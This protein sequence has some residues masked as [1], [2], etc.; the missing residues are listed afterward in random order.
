MKAPEWRQNVLLVS[1]DPEIKLFVQAAF[2]KETQFMTAQNTREAIEQLDA[3]AVQVIIIDAKTT[4][5]SRQFYEQYY[6]EKD[7]IPFIELSQYANQLN[8]GLTVI[9]LVNK[10]LSKESDFARKCGATLIMDR[11]NILTNRMIYLIGVMRKRT[12]RSILSHDISEGAVF[13]VDLYHYLSSSE[14]YAIFLTAG[15]PFTAEKKDKIRVSN[16][17]HLYVYETDL[18]AFFAVLRKTNDSILFS[19]SLASIRNQFRH[20]LIQLFDLSTDGM[21]HFGKDFY[22]RGLEITTE[23]EKLISR[24]PDDAT[25]LRELPYPRWSTLAHSVNC[26]I[27]AIIF[28]KHCHFEHTNEIAFA[29]MI[30]NVGLSE[31]NQELVRKKETELS[32]EEFEKYKKHV[33]ITVELLR[34]KLIPFTPLIEKIILHHHENYDGTGFPDGLA[35]ENLPLECA[36]V[37]ILSSFDYFNTVRPGEKPTTAAQAWQLLKKHHGDSTELNKK[38]HP[39]LL[40]QL[41]E[42]FVKV[43]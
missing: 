31:I 15:A 23:L 43:G 26:G 20:L 37:S 42:F 13:S 40:A 9:L 28:S 24:F 12:F 18:G 3:S 25:C 32:S 27:Y 30:H 29:S 1:D 41:D 5:P 22:D 35:G 7:E 6:D 14:R 39:K 21:V 33:T 36:L 38:F 17:R 10:L 11:K 16:I 34:E 8:L 2:G 4:N 19:D